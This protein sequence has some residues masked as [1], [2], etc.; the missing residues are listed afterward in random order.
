MKQDPRIV[1]IGGVAAGPKAAARARRLLPNAEITVIDRGRWISYA[2][3]GMPFF[4]DGQVNTFEELFNTAYDVIRDEGYFL[5]EKGITVLTST[6]AMEID[7]AKKMI[8]IKDLAGQEERWIPYDKLVVA[9]GASPIIPPIEGR[10]LKGV[11]GLNNPDDLLR[12]ME[13]VG[14]VNEAVVV[15]AGFIGMEVAGALSNRNILTTVVELRDQILP[16]VLDEDLAGVLKTRLESQ[17]IDFALGQKVIRFED[18]NGRVARVVTDRGSL[19]AEMVVM[20]VGVRPNVEPALKAGLK[21]GDTGAIEVNEYMQTSDPDIYACGDCAEN[22]NI[23]SGR[24]TYVP[25]A[26]SANRQGRVVGDNI[27]GRRSRY[28]GILGTALLQVKNWN[29]GRTGL[30]EQQAQAL[31]YETQTAIT[32]AHDRS[33]YHPNHSLVILKVIAEEGTGRLLGV[34]GIGPGGLDK[35]ID[36]AAT[37]ISFGATLDNLVDLDLGYAPPYNTTIDALQHT[38]NTLRNKKSGLVPMISPRKVWEKL[39]SGDDFVLLDVR[40][41]R[42]HDSKPMN[43][44]R[45]IHVIMGELRERIDSIP[46]DKEI[47]VF[48]DLG[49]RSYE[50]LRVLKGAG[51]TNIRSMEGGMRLWAYGPVGML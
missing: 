41:Q 30:G 12:L 42:E 26:S 49:I 14:D 8:R 50:A 11:H 7:R 18:E 22:V 16:G 23:L 37:A 40:T 51:F 10:D 4:L 38:A 48:C 19:D 46:R 2:G 1:I 36:V 24:H 31:G 3:C 35:R 43:D 29:V 17:G 45:V 27:A 33:H 47:V 28:N 13:T 21:I 20:A 25:L 44:E 32:P 6:E 15:G 5:R 34:Q 39:Q 9:T